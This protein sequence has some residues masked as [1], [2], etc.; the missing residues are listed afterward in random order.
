MLL[1]VDSSMHADIVLRQQQDE[2]G[3]ETDG[4]A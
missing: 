1:G 4:I 3:P 2:S